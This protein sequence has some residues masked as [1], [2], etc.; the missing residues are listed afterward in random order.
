MPSDRSGAGRLLVRGHS[1]ISRNC[2]WDR[3]D[4]PKKHLRQTQYF[5]ATAVVLD[6][7]QEDN[8]CSRNTLGFTLYGVT[9][10]NCDGL[11]KAGEIHGKCNLK[12]TINRS[13]RRTPCWKACSYYRRRSRDGASHL[14]SLRQ[15]R[16]LGNDS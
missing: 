8:K 5:I 10:R 15:R 1:Q 14:L 7:F 12:S 2:S 3:T 9:N 6:F 11:I 13:I 16:R 4:T